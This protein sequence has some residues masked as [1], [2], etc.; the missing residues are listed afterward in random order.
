[1][2][3][4]TETEKNELSVLIGEIFKRDQTALLTAIV[5]FSPL[6]VIV[7]DDNGCVRA[8]NPAAERIFGWSEQEILGKALPTIP[9]EKQR[10]FE[11]INAAV[12][13]GETVVIKRTQ[14]LNKNGAAVDVHLSVAPVTGEYG[15]VEGRFGILADIS[16]HLRREEKLQESEEKY[17][18]ILENMEEGYHEV[19]L[20]GSFTFFNRSFGRIMGY[21]AEELLGMN[22]REYAADEE[23]RKRIFAAYNRVFRTGAPLESFNWDIIRKDGQRRTVEVSASL[24]RDKDGR[25]AGFRG[26]VRDVT[27][28]RQNVERLRKA[29]GATIQAISSLVETRDPYTAGHQRRV[30]DLARSIATEL[31]LSADR[32]D[33]L[34]MAAIIHDIGKISVPAEILS[35][36]RRLTEIEFNLIKTH[37]EAGYRILKD[38]DFPWPICRIILEHH[39]RMNGS[40]YPNGLTGD[41]ILMESRILAV[42]DVV[43]SMASHRPYRASLGLEAALAEITGHKGELYDAEVVDACLRLFRE[44]QYQFNLP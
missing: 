15:R 41:M 24:I 33:G 31:G 23:N 40:G 35:M 2:K 10:E 4:E 39:E 21:R 14:W 28:R 6:A 22:Y 36:P 37:A 32:I 9:R 13:Q 17:R 7:W 20:R 16:D 8:W 43:E 34:R 29:L 18:V 1:M 38:I 19:D 30:A 11:E 12:R 44:R 26:I 5:T 27:E 25:P 3:M 42:A